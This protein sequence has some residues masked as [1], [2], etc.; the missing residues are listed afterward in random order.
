M[1][2]SMVGYTA[3]LV[4][5]RG[6]RLAMMLAIVLGSWLSGGITSAQTPP[7]TAEALIG[8]SVSEVG[9]RYADVNE[10]IKRFQNR[11]VLGA[12]RFLESAKQKDPSL[13][14]TAL[15]L[16]KMYFLTGN[17]GSGRASLEKTAQDDPKDPESSLILADQAITQGRSIEAEALYE[18][19]LAL[20][21]QFNQNAKRKRHMEIRAR[22]G[23]ALV[24][25]RRRNWQAA[26]DDLQ[27]LVQIDPENA[28]AHYRLG[29]ALFML[30]KPKEGYDEFVK[31]R[32]L[33]KNLPNP[34]V[35]SA[36]MYD[37]LADATRAQKAFDSA[38]K[39]E[40]NNANTLAAYGQWLI[41]TGSIEK[42]EATL[43]EARKA[44]PASLD[45]LILSGVAA[46]MAKKMKP[47]ED[48][49]MEALRISPTNGGV[50]NQL[51]LLLIDQPDEDKRRRALEFANM[52]SRLNN[53]STEARITLAW[54][55]Y[56]LGRL[57]E[58]NA[59][60][61]QGLQLGNPNPDSSYLVAKILVDQNQTDAAK[62]LLQSSLESEN[63]GM[64]VHEQ[65]ARALLETLGK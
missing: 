65:E 7:L 9:T 8:D 48:Y 34:F 14:P 39:D 2:R 37:Q 35:A 54:V 16:A 31:A 10:A 17:A 4:G 58:A 33:D 64:F 62:Q 23:R 21:E 20:T 15:L 51:A 56:Q 44:N 52:N 13:P 50:I 59:A 49:F 55:L 18:K 27:A 25:E 3:G 42:A 6:N 43:E 63:A 24:A 1:N 47:A 11:D 36:L 40:A 19:G 45:T 32:Q 29:R 57:Q 22:T 5:S 30:N 53:E 26:A 41:K 12:Q 46:S 60:L 38:V 61:Q 28:A